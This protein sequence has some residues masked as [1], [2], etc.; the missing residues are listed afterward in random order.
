M[1]QHPFGIICRRPPGGAVFRVLGRVEGRR[2]AG[3]RV[4]PD[5]YCVFN[6]LV[7]DLSQQDINQEVY[8]FLA[9]AGAK[10]GVGFWRPGSG[11]IHQVKQGLA[12]LSRGK[13]LGCP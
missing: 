4:I 1:G 5:A 2:G 10:Y 9:T 12:C 7:I 3:A 13:G 6:A 8:N 11:I